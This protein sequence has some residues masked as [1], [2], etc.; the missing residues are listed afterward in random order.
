MIA[1]NSPIV[2]LVCLLYFWC[3]ILKLSTRDV[4]LECLVFDSTVACMST[5]ERYYLV[6]SFVDQLLPCFEFL[7]NMEFFFS[8]KGD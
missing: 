7:L 4:P 5:V 3:F 2:G 6:C 1:S 8:D